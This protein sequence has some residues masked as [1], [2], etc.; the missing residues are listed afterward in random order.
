[1]RLDVPLP[2][3]SGEPSSVW[4]RSIDPD[5]SKMN[6]MLGRSACARAGVEASASPANAAN[7]ARTEARILF[8]G[9][10][11][12]F[13]VTGATGRYGSNGTQPTAGEPRSRARGWWRRTAAQARAAPLATPCCR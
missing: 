4:L 8:D 9:I 13:L 11:I 10:F 6:M 2:L 7:P 5:V 1:M 12:A 3:H